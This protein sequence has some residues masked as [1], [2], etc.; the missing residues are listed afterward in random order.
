MVRTMPSRVMVSTYPARIREW[1]M[2]TQ[3]TAKPWQCTRHAVLPSIHRQK[4]YIREDHWLHM[5]LVDG[6]QWH[7]T[8]HHNC[9]M[10]T[11]REFNTGN[12]SF[13][14]VV[15]FIHY[16]QHKRKTHSYKNK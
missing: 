3:V 15:G 2:V 13:R 6:Q 10:Y 5:C 9:L 12:K 8:A 1:L 16:E 4:Y 11:A 7:I 14:S